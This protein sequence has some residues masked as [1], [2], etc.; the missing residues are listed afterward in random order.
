MPHPARRPQQH[1]VQF[2]DLPPVV[3][4][5]G[6]SITGSYD[7]DDV[8]NV[9]R[10][11]VP[12]R[13]SAV[14]AP[15]QRCPEAARLIQAHGEKVLQSLTEESSNTPASCDKD[16][17]PPDK[18][19]LEPADAT[20]TVSHLSTGSRASRES[21]GTSNGDPRPV[22]PLIALTGTYALGVKPGSGMH[23]TSI[24]ASHHRPP[25]KT[26]GKSSRGDTDAGGRTDPAPVKPRSKRAPDKLGGPHTFGMAKPARAMSTMPPGL[27]GPG[28]PARARP[29]HVVGH[30]GDSI[31]LI[32]TGSIAEHEQGPAS[33]SQ[34]SLTPPRVA[35]Q[36][37][38]VSLKGT[39]PAQ[40]QA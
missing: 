14:A 7:G 15:S 3:F 25:A 34:S 18:W 1:L 36:S 27:T 29:L 12:A 21:R 8:H 38:E 13:Q 9:A 10:F 2:G 24:R 40:N 22:T 20:I 4:N 17:V 5:I 19:P 31:G 30:D 33:D 23:H 32:K 39:S 16:A 26:F 35:G 28:P 37:R 6:L 11:Q